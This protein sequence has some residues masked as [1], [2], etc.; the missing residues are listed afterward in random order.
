LRTLVEKGFSPMDYRYLLLGARYS[1]PLGF[2]YEALEAARNAYRK[3][4]AAVCELPWK[5]EKDGRAGKVDQALWQ[6][7]LAYASDDLDTPK[8]LA[9]QWE[10]LKDASLSPANKKATIL[11]I[12]SLLGLAKV[13]DE[14]S[15]TGTA[16]SDSRIPADVQALLDERAAART[17]KD[18]KKSDELRDRIVA[19]G[20]DVKDGPD[21]QKITKR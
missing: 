2:S 9:L 17:A 6:K 14:A 10:I 18:W 8:V 1:T 5:D 15:G 4:N 3:M 20:Y 13:D 19:L 7:A 12:D 21:G 11:K 16:T